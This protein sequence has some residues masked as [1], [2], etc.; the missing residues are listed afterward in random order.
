M[1]L[2]ILK[3]ILTS[4]RRQVLS[5]VHDDD[6]GDDDWYHYYYYHYINVRQKSQSSVCN[7]AN[8]NKSSKYSTIYIFLNAGEYNIVDYVGPKAFQ[9]QK[10]IT[11]TDTVTEYNSLIKYQ[12]R[13]VNGLSIYGYLFN[14]VVWMLHPWSSIE[15]GQRWSICY[16][17]KKRLG[18]GH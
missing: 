9:F 10:E 12:N 8:K 16:Q 13:T 17:D 4:W 3:S 5:N 2:Y 18:W 15:R 14:T 7:E 11:I 1:D 6:D